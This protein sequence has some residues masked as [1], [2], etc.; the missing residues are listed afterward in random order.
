MGIALVALGLLTNALLP[1]YT[2]EIRDGREAPGVA[3]Y[4]VDRWGGSVELWATGAER[5][6]WLNIAPARK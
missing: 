1:R 4:R 3:I 5:P 2:F 6:Q